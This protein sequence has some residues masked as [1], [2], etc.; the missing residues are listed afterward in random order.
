MS[1]A[2]RVLLWQLQ[3][4]SNRIVP[5]AAAGG[6]R[7]DAQRL[8]GDPI[9]WVAGQGMSLRIQ[10][11]PIWAA[12]EQVIAVSV[13][14][15]D[16]QPVV[17]TFEMID[18]APLQA[19]QFDGLGVYL[20]GMIGIEAERTLLDTQQARAHELIETLRALPDAADVDTL[21]RHLAR[22]THAM[23]GANGSVVVMMENSVGTVVAA[24]GDAPSIGTH[25]SA[26]ESELALAAK[27]AT[28]FMR[29]HG[30]L[31]ALP[32]VAAGERIN[33]KPVALVAVPLRIEGTVEG[34]LAGWSTTDIPRNGIQDL[35]TLAPYAALQ[36][37]RT[38]QFGLLRARAEHDPLTGMNNRAA[39]E[40]Q[41]NGE[42]ARYDRYQRPFAMIMIDIDHFKSVNDRHGHEGGDFVLKQVSE[43]VRT[44]LR[45]VDFS[46][47]L[48]GEEFVVLLP[49]TGLAKA[50]DIAERVRQRVE[51]HSADWRGQQMAVTISAGVAAIPESVR[52]THQL[53]RAADAALYVS[54]REGRNRVTAAP[55]AKQ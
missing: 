19:T 27:A 8:T 43:I 14:L 55:S 17:A 7:P 28:T 23:L 16:D 42:S 29:A 49:E 39:F 5:I 50:L 36:L 26:S 21:S 45:N 51:S 31:G 37:E 4:I 1:G 9:S 48:G 32:L 11:A 13:G 10:P 30:S 44:S 18:T 41:L 20:G 3:R 34:L 52:Y 2:Q 47:R 53:V 40:A 35:E 25:F 6:A 38:R 54:K 15:I 33:V 12:A 46:A 22:L 24:E